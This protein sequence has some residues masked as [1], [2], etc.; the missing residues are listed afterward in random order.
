MQSDTKVNRFNND[1]TSIC[2]Y[3]SCLS[4]LYFQTSWSFFKSSFE[5]L[6]FF[7]NEIVRD[8]TTITPAFAHLIW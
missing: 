5:L 8:L 4:V 2:V 6:E 3:F 1:C 7:L